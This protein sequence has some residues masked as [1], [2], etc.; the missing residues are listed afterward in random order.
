MDTFT[1][2]LDKTLTEL[3]GKMAKRA[4]GSQFTQG[5]DEIA[6]APRVVSALSQREEGNRRHEV[7]EGT[8]VVATVVACSS[9]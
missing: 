6:A 3:R 7:P 4:A 9:T 5:N 2:R 1:S 8:E